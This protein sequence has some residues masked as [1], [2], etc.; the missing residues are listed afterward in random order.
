MEAAVIDKIGA[1][2]QAVAERIALE[3]KGES[4]YLPPGATLERAEYFA[5]R[6]RF[7]RHHYETER[8]ID[9]VN[10]T[11]KAAATCAESRPAVYVRPDGSSARAVFDHGAHGAAEWG[12]HRASL[13][14]RP[15]PAWA[16]AQTMANGVRS[17]QQVI[18][19]MEDWGAGTLTAHQADGTEV[20]FTRAVAALR[21]VKIEARA[22]SV[23]V[24][25]NMARQRSALESIEASGD[26]D[27]LPAYFVLHSPLYVGTCE[28]AIVMRLGVRE[29]DGKPAL[30]LRIVGQDRLA[31]ETSAWVE[32]YLVEHLG[33]SL[34]GV[35]VGTLEIG[36]P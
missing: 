13:K 35:Y 4:L 9:F 28:L 34:D 25:G 23:S 36:K 19:W 3:T 7:H 30:A 11:R 31:E 17:Q 10:Y 27:T 2:N 6:P 18:D 15:T 21:R 22:S 33:Q 12:H 1:L 24:E 32:A 5:A 29:T 8:L 26:T 16:A 20:E 14:L